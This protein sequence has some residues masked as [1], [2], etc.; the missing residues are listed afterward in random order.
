MRLIDA[1]VII[2]DLTAMKSLYDAIKLDGMIK[3]L[4]KAPTI[5]AVPVVHGEWLNFIGDYST[6]E[7][8]E[9]GECCEVSPDDEP[10][11]EFFELF[12]ELYRFCPRCGARMDRKA[13]RDGR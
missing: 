7:C 1:D 4:K 5:K 3:A 9:C 8:S 2:R 10:K 6:A 13:V 12:K 11:A